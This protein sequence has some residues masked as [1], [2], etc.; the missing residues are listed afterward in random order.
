MTNEM[1]TTL[2]VAEQ[3][4]VTPATVY[5]WAQSGTIPSTR[6]GRIL[7]FRPE[8]IEA[9]SS[10]GIIAQPEEQA[11]AENS[12]SQNGDGGTGG[13]PAIP[14]GTLTEAVLNALADL[15]AERL[16]AGSRAA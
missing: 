8:D 15:V 5:R 3:L 10:Q 2:E 14:E 16:R 6:I 9:L 4:H 12:P 13:E 11:P 1:L 7:R